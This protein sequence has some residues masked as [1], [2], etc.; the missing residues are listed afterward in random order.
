MKQ[1]AQGMVYELKDNEWV[2][3]VELI[4][5]DEH[6]IHKAIFSTAEGAS[7]DI[8]YSINMLNN[9]FYPDGSYKPLS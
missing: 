6:F 2:G 3:V 1:A 9:R 8:E 4:F 7:E 5:T